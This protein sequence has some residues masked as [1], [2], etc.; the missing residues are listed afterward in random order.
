MKRKGK[1]L[2]T[3]KRKGREKERSKGKGR[4]TEETKK[5]RIHLWSGLGPLFEQIRMAKVS[6]GVSLV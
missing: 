6:L 5:E 2:G 1:R 4:E 3:R